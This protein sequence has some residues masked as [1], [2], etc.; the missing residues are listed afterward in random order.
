M[1]KN[2][3]DSLL[4][5]SK[6]HS[7]LKDKMFVTLYAEDLYFLVSRG[8][9]LVTYIYTHYIFHQSK[10]KKDSVIMNQKSCQTASSKV[11]KDFCKLFNN[12]NFGSDCRNNIDNCSLEL[13]YDGINEIHYMKRYTNIITDQKCRDLFSPDLMRREMEGEF[14]EKLK[15]LN[16]EDPAYEAILEYFER[17]KA[18][19][20]DAVD[21][22]VKKMK[23]KKRKLESI[24]NKISMCADP[25]KTKMTIEFNELEAACV[26]K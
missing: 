10:F 13:V 3:I 11:E 25:R 23:A 1:K 15:N 12:S 22:F 17:R 20:L 14:E 18:E 2:E 16:K 26:K 6:T 5:K 21:S 8:G 24:E 4:Y 19:D 9:W 7:T